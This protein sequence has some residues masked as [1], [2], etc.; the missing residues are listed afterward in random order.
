MKGASLEDVCGKSPAE[1]I[2]GGKK[3]MAERHGGGAFG[4]VHKAVTQGQL[5]V[6]I[7]PSSAAVGRETGSAL[8]PP[9]VCV[10]E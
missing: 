7:G 6:H 1:V 8:P 3:E 10:L 9:F 5:P 4:V 2:E